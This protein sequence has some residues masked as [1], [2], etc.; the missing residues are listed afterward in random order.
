MKAGSGTLMS[1]STGVNVRIGE[2]QDKWRERRRRRSR[3]RNP[4][5]ML[6]Q[7]WRRTER[8]GEGWKGVKVV[9]EGGEEEAG[10]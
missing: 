2:I 5:V 7:H 4:S 6:G 10:S 3:L 8:G 9:G 1:D